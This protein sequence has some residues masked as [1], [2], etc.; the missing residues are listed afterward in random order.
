M[1]RLLGLVG[2]VRTLLWRKGRTFSTRRIQ[3]T[4]VYAHANDK[5][6]LRAAMAAEM[7]AFRK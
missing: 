5:Q 3:N 2:S 7:G 6:G 1:L 4:M